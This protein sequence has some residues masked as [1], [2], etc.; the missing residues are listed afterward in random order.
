MISEEGNTSGRAGV[1]MVA[2]D[3]TDVIPFPKTSKDDVEHR[4]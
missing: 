2:G 4:L 1:W 3:D